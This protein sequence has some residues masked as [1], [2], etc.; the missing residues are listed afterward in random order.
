MNLEWLRNSRFLRFCVVGSGGALV[1][2]SVLAFG[3][4]ILALDPYS[5]RGLSF[6]AAV[7]FT[8]WGNR[9]LTFAD[10]KAT[11][12]AAIL[13]EW[14]RFLSANGI[15]GII[16]YGV[17]ALC[18]TFAPAPLNNPYLAMIVSV[19][20]GLTFNFTLSSKVVFRAGN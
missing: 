4:N 17:Y 5:A 11:E 8:W 12:V 18:V 14:F 6:L 15:G 19:F 1:D 9:Q 20:V 7:T 2:F 13:R 16:N 10:R 3:L